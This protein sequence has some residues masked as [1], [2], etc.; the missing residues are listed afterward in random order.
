[1]DKSIRYGLI[2]AGTLSV[3]LAVGFFLGM[4][5]ATDLWFWQDSRLSYIFISS[6][7]AAIGIPVIWIG[8][9]REF[10][11]LRGGALDLAPTDAGAAI[12]LF[13]ESRPTGD[14]RLWMGSL[15]FVVLFFV[16]VGVYF[17]SRRYSTSDPRVLPPPVRYSFVI[18]ALVLIGV[19][20]LLVLRLPNIFPWPLKPNSSVLYGL[21]FWGAAVYFIHAILH[22]KWNYGAGQL[23]GFLAYDLI[24]IGPFLAHFANVLPEQRTSLVIYTTVL[25]YSG[26]LAIYYLFINK[27][28][29]IWKLRA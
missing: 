19:G 6:I 21:I 20:T 9:S 27:P 14:P 17:W 7:L 24:L 13:L 23:A 8:W 4:S 16:S 25:L 3:V 22:P 12:F 10:A 2:A 26:A 15:A 5:W 1:M 11:A 18:F 29:Q 28:T